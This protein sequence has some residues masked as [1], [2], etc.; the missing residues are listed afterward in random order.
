MSNLTYTSGDI[1]NAKSTVVIAHIVN[2]VGAFGAGF[3]KGLAER[4]PQAKTHYH[5]NFSWYKLGDVL[6]S[7]VWVPE[8]GEPS[9]V[10][11]LFA[12]D[13]LPSKDNP[14]P[15]KYL[16]LARALDE[17]AETVLECGPAYEV[18]MPRIGTGYAR[19]HWGIIEPMIQETLVYRGIKVV[20]WDLPVVH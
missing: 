2:N 10:A 6:M 3:A 12:Q 15:I 19:G 8:T 18:W 9:T 11:H 4:Y 5:A 7:S 14:T 20:V 13:G 1:F 17:L 16:A